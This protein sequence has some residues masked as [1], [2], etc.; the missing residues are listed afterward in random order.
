M[1]FLR[2][3][4]NETY[5]HPKGAPFIFTSKRKDVLEHA[6]LSSSTSIS[7]E[8]LDLDKIYS[9]DNSNLF[10]FGGHEEQLHFGYQKSEICVIYNISKKKVR[11]FLYR[12]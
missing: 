2:L 11:T 9:L 8:F 7:P 6:I 10:L 5:H 4:C 1:K 3:Q 12:L